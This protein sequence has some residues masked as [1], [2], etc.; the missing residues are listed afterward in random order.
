MRRKKIL[1]VG[2][3]T[4]FCLSAFAGRIG[5]PADSAWV[6]EP[7][8][9]WKVWGGELPRPIVAPLALPAI[10][11]DQRIGAMFSGGRADGFAGSCLIPVIE[12]YGQ[13]DF[14]CV[15]DTIVLQLTARGSNLQYRWQKFNVNGYYDVKPDPDARYQ[16]LGTPKLL[17]RQVDKAKDD[18]TYRC[19]VWNECEETVSDS[20]RVKINYAPVINAG[21]NKF[22]TYVCTSNRP[23]QLALNASSPEGNQRYTWSRRDTVTGK[24]VILQPLDDYNSPSINITPSTR[25]VQGMYMVEVLNECGSVRDST[26]LPVLSPVRITESNVDPKVGMRAC[27]GE[28]VNFRIKVDGGGSYKYAFC[29]ANV[30]N[31]VFLDYIVGDTI[32][33]GSSQ[34]CLRSVTAAMQGY[35]VW[36]VENECGV[37]EKLIY[38][39]VFAYPHFTKVPADTLNACEGSELE[40]SCFATG[41]DVKYY[42]KHNGEDMGV[43]GETLKIDSLLDKDAGGYVCYAKNYCQRPVPTRVI[44]VGVSPRPKF[45]RH[46]FLYRPACEGD[47]SVSMATELMSIP[48][49]SLR[50]YY[51]GN[52]MFD[53]PGKREACD[54]KQVYIYNIEE[55][56]IGA[57]RVAAWN[58]C[59]V[60]HSNLTYLKINQPARIVKGLDSYTRLLLCAGETK[61][62]KIMA[63]GTEPI[64]YRWLQ[65]D[66]VI[67]ESETNETIIKAGQVDTTAQYSVHVQNMCGGDLVITD[68]QVAKIRQFRLEGGGSYCDG[69]EAIGDINMIDSDT[70]I[71]YTLFRKP[72]IPVETFHGTG[73]TLKFGQLEGGTYYVVGVD[74]NE[75]SDKMKNE[76]FVE[77]KK[78]PAKGR[79]LLAEQYCVGNTGARLLQTAWEKDVQYRMYSLQGTEWKWHYRMAFWGGDI[80]SGS[81][82]SPDEHKIWEGIDEGKYKVVAT[83]VLN[84]CTTDMILE[85]SI[86]IRPMPRVYKLKAKGDDWINCSLEAGKVEL[87]TDGYEKGYKYTLFKDGAKYGDSKSYSPIR[88][89]LLNGG[90]YTMKVENE[91]GC[92]SE[93][94][95]VKVIDEPSP[96][97]VWIEEN[98]TI[99]KGDEALYKELTLKESEKGVFYQIHRTF[100]DQF[101]EELVGTGGEIKCVLPPTNAAYSIIAYSPSRACSVRFEQ[102]YVV[103]ASDFQL[104]TNPS[105]IFVD[106]G[107]RT[108]MHLNING[109]YSKPIVVDW[110]PRNKIE[111]GLF[112]NTGSQYHKQYYAP[113]CPCGCKTYENSWN[114]HQYSHGLSCNA[115]NCP[116][117]YHQWDPKI[118]GCHYVQT[119]QVAYGGRMVSYY[120][121]YYC[122]K[123]NVGEGEIA[124]PDPVKNEYTDPSTVPMYDDQR[125]T[126][127]VTDGMGCTSTAEVQVNVNGGRL[128]AEI[129]SSELTRHY[130]PGFCK[131]CSVDRWG[132]IINRHWKHGSGCNVN[133]CWLFYHDKSRF[134]D[135]AYQGTEK[136]YYNDSWRNQ[137]D[138]YYCCTGSHAK[139][140][141][142]YKYTDMYFCSEATGGDW[143]FNYTW[144]FVNEDGL[145]MPITQT[146]DRA[147]FIATESGFLYLEVTS[148]GQYKRDSIWIEVMRKPL[149]S[150]I[151]DADCQHLIDSVYV[152]RGETTT[153]CGWSEGGDKPRVLKWYD[154]DTY[155]SG[156]PYIT[157]KPEQSGYVWFEVSSD[158]VVNIDSVYVKVMNSPV[159]LDIV[160]PGVRCTQP[161]KEE[162]IKLATSEKNI[163]YVL[164]YSVDNRAFIEITHREPTTDGSAV[165]FR[166]GD[167]VK[168]A[169][170]YRIRADRQLG[171]N[172]CSTYTD[173]LELIRPPSPD[174]L[175]DT[176]YCPGDNGAL[177]SLKSTGSNM[178]YTICSA[179]GID[180]ETITAPERFFKKKFQQATYQ[181]LRERVGWTGSCIE[182]DTFGVHRRELPAINLQVKA[183]SYHGSICEGEEVRITIIATEDK[184]IYELIDPEGQKL[185]SLTGDGTDKTFP[186]FAGLSA[187]RYIIKADREGCTAYLDAAVKINSSPKAVTVPDI[188]YCYL[189]EQSPNA[190]KIPLEIKGLEQDVKYYLYKKE[191]LIDSVVGPG[192]KLYL[193]QITNGDYHIQGVDELTGCTSTTS[194]FAV[195]ANKAPNPFKLGTACGAV[196]SV[197]LQSSEAGVTYYLHRNSVRIAELPGTGERL[198][199][200]PQTVSGVYTVYAVDQKT[201]CD[202]WMEG[203]ITIY[204]LDSCRMYADRALCDG[205]AYGFGVSICYPCAATGWDFYLQSRDDRGRKTKTEQLPGNGGPLWWTYYTNGKPLLDGLYELHAVNTACGK[206]ILWDTLRIKREAPI[207]GG[208][209][210][211]N[212]L[213]ACRGQEVSVQI[214]AYPDI[215]YH[216]YSNIDGSRKW[217]KDMDGPA[218]KDIVTMG[219]FKNYWNFILI[220]QTKEGTCTK[221]FSPVYV[222][223]LSTPDKIEILGRDVCKTDEN[224]VLNICLPH[225]RVDTITYS[226]N[227]YGEGVVDVITGRKLGPDDP[228]PLNACFAAQKKIG[229]YFVVGEN[230]VTSCKDTMLNAYYL[231]A[232]PVARH[233]SAVTDRVAVVT[234]IN[235]C[236]GNK[237]AIEVLQADLIRYQ[238]YRRDPVTLAEGPWGEPVQSYGG[239]QVLT[240][241]I[242]EPGLYW[243]KAIGGDGCEAWMLDSITVKVGEAPNMKI[244]KDY[245]ICPGEAGA[246]IGMANGEKDSKCWLYKGLKPIDALEEVIVARTGDSVVFRTLCADP[247]YYIVVTNS[248]WGCVRVDT[249][250]VDRGIAPRPVRLTSSSDEWLCEGG[251][252]IFTLKNV[253]RLVEYQLFLDNE[254]NEAGFALGTFEGDTI[255]FDEISEEGKYYV[256]A[257]NFYTPRCSAAMP[258]TLTLAGVDSIR[259]FRILAKD[260][261]Y[262]FY[263][264]D[265]YATLWLE[266]YEA[267]VNYK[268]LKDDSL[269]YE[270]DRG[271]QPPTWSRVTG[272]VCTGLQTTLYSGSEYKVLA[273]SDKNCKKLMKNVVR[274]VAQDYIGKV[275]FY[276]SDVYEARGFE[277]C[278]GDSMN[279]IATANGCHLHYSWWR[280]ADSLHVP[281]LPYLKL[282]DLQVGDLGIYK[283]KVSNTCG[284]V[285]AGNIPLVVSP[286]VTL[287]REMP[288]TTLCY[289]APAYIASMMNNVMTGNYR[290]YRYDRPDETLS[291]EPFLFFGRVTL[292]DAGLY[293]CEGEGRCNTV[294]DTFRVEVAMSPDSIHLQKTFDTLCVGEMLQIRLDP[295]KIGMR[296]EDMAWQVNGIATGQVGPTFVVSKVSRKNEGIYA[297][298][299]DNVC[300]EKLFPVMDVTVDDSLKLL[301]K[302]PDQFLCVA[303]PLQLYI[304]TDPWKNVKYTWSLDTV[305][306]HTESI[307]VEVPNISDMITYNIDYE[308][309]CGRERT[310]VRL[311]V[312]R[313]AT[314]DAPP[315]QILM[316][317]GDPD[318]TLWVIPHNPALVQDYTWIYRPH[319]ENSKEDTLVNRSQTQN[320]YT[321]SAVTSN[322]GF[323]YCILAF[324]CGRKTAETTWVRVD[325]TPTIAGLPAEKTLCRGGTIPL[326]ATATGGSVIYTWKLLD[327]Q[328]NLIKVLQEDIGLDSVTTK[329]CI[330]GPVTEQYEG[331]ILRCVVE[332]NCGRDSMQTLLHVDAPRKLIVTTPYVKACAGDVARVGVRL[333]NGAH[334]W[335]YVYTDEDGDVGRGM[336]DN[337]TN[338]DT[339]EVTRSGKYIVTFLTDGEQCNYAE[340]IDSFHV[341]FIPRTTATLSVAGKDLLC[342]GAEARLRITI[343]PPEG[344]N[345]Q[346]QGPWEVTIIKDG[347]AAVEINGGNAIQIT[348]ADL[349]GGKIVKEISFI[350]MSS[351]TYYLGT[352]IDKG[353]GYAPCI[354]DVKGKAEFKIGEQD[355]LKLAYPSKLEMFGIC[356]PV[357]LD[358]LFR[359]NIGNGTYKVDGAVVES[360]I[361]NPQ[362]GQGNDIHQLKPGIHTVTYIVD[363]ACADSI[364]VNLWLAERPG[365]NVSPL[366]TGLCEKQTAFINITPTGKGPFRL[367]YDMK[368][369]YRN[370]TYL[371]NTNDLSST[372]F[373]GT[374]RVKVTNSDAKNEARRTITPVLLRDKFGCPA[375]DTSYRQA[376]VR[377]Q[378][379]P[380]FQLSAQHPDSLEGHW[381]T[382]RST[383][384]IA[385]DQV[386]KMR[387]HMVSGDK[388]WGFRYMKNVMPMPD[389]FDKVY[390]GLM[391][392]DTVVIADREGNYQFYPFSANQCIN[393]TKNEAQKDVFYR[394]GGYIRLKVLLEGAYDESANRMRTVLAES[395]LLP[396]RGLT[397]LPVSSGGHKVVDWITV[398]AREQLGM[399]PISRDT[400]LLCSD[401]QVIDRFGNDTLSLKNTNNLWNTQ[402]WH[403]VVHHRN[404]LTVMSK[405]SYQVVSGDDKSSVKSIDL[406]QAAQVYT[407][408]ANAAD[409]VGFMTQIKPN[410]WAMAAGYDNK[411]DML[412]SIANPH[413][414]LS[415]TNIEWQKPGYYDKDVTLDGR[416]DWPDT[417]DLTAPGVVA[418]DNLFSDPALKARYKAKDAWILHKN[419]NKYS[420]VPVKEP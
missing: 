317:A 7:A 298:Q 309:A 228:D 231:N 266:N 15:S 344:Q 198:S 302:T 395:K 181:L 226:L 348:S 107:N 118:N 37:D 81:P 375:A 281:G 106:R 390:N 206:D 297:I 138:I 151:K 79:L 295:N 306:G 188:E 276:P 200:G 13:M 235:M 343:T 296:A 103:G 304:K 9:T 293:V 139:D 179:T 363:G 25:E 415:A 183:E 236:V 24:T 412:V 77:K 318:T 268:L 312:E 322:T 91:W 152:C 408:T 174:E 282:K 202:M 374:H 387:L 222:T 6:G 336:Q 155:I 44:R 267:G 265:G 92:F 352:V 137:Y 376:V 144:T 96:K 125:F 255:V 56:D 127:T 99:C 40:L 134:K 310:S 29:K 158:D 217:L 61:S 230:Q 208:L 42:W 65:N 173:D 369:A 62:L 86:V 269:Y 366:D 243:V 218:V 324:R 368:I 116:Y 245:Y 407:S 154:K 162:I 357:G 341:E 384:V 49:D 191:K 102:K 75:C 381:E 213:A 339:I 291:T 90:T 48:Y 33:T 250:M 204:E 234:E 420:I 315:K 157:Y 41:I 54:Q 215:T 63:T 345:F 262:C 287:I 229:N 39:Q 176:T 286:E 394:E 149:E 180:L 23:I 58:R 1:I 288:D 73:D 300:G 409:V 256:I 223:P 264:P 377:M 129:V 328:G 335:S 260:T 88:W 278:V 64:H 279:Y 271:V 299:F 45:L 27:E 201:T 52:P 76:I 150:G 53:K 50:W 43:A 93:T 313:E 241:D 239:R 160:D 175:T 80:S 224:A 361:F 338:V 197:V 205:E 78:A 94:R 163:A 142:V 108:S 346:G 219:T 350:I 18:G 254:D 89:S 249:L 320:W 253:Q 367:T 67:A 334:P 36:R 124:K 358:T 370:G 399:D 114:M 185:S 14:A 406:T 301:S 289:G 130:Y 195:I 405:D 168:D 207:R 258:D 28:D 71:V 242:T 411:I 359:P 389:A 379:Y 314:Y 193:T 22:E 203:E 403:I 330:L 351:A 20:F 280:D 327:H 117:I 209:V 11:S 261:V 109:I 97:Q 360:G 382:Y 380:V 72:E 87:I 123:S 186:A 216:L 247:G 277:R 398:E 221:E 126:V 189:A 156:G 290:W 101:V 400:F 159:K 194:G 161:G 16:G 184:V 292:R 135:C 30:I 199:F 371:T 21:L 119:E 284:T 274:V 332:N 82:A 59:G 148:M 136:I 404:H 8:G 305:V 272:D 347:M 31:D 386:V 373:E 19:I 146:T 329:E 246:Q 47:D 354:G 321:I 70:S 372:P 171:D 244:D 187:G 331:Y 5:I 115:L 4:L 12:S 35:Y 364:K 68:L 182:R 340:G 333:E 38:L 26:F 349:V 362:L 110:Q 190:V 410:V 85:D 32:Q 172:V 392:D 192:T 251:S 166:V 238:I 388:P 131:C 84:G 34:V 227:L 259:D 233:V 69:H 196:D 141:T 365:L 214:E 98:G 283:V 46:P 263:Q 385:S 100:P 113:F 177:I 128:A 353:Q 308:N 248:R 319:K 145:A 275:D 355:A 232:V 122:D 401:G 147:Q 378:M 133:T 17:I 143:K 311:R 111:W 285:Y 237:A 57:Y 51:G 323:Y 307:W 419:R 418:G 104:E 417:D 132:N 74:T 273:V 210:M 60:T 120:D 414:A 169:G 66:E 164:E 10:S 112:A 325:T 402:K 416:V 397:V 105:E 383:Y 240:R 153:F 396:M 165:V 178:K 303:M 3:L 326:T 212:S 316:C 257:T 2:L 337:G 413:K 83:D 140:T 220:G 294:A 95:S 393:G 356:Q 342:R 167:A 211:S 252:T 55:E 270:S 170:M 121:L 391:T 225:T